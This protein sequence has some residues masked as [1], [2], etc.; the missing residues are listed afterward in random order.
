MIKAIAGK[1]NGL[2][3]SNYW[4]INEKKVTIGDY[5]IVENKKG[6]DLVEVTGIL[7]T[8]EEHIN[9]IIGNQINKKVIYVIPK[10]VWE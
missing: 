1:L 10:K 9:Q 2:N 5:V 8:D 4:L 6:Y 7:E 3:V